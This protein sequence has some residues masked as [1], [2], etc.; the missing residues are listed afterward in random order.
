MYVDIYTDYKSTNH[1]ALDFHIGL[2]ELYGGKITV[3]QLVLTIPNPIDFVKNYGKIG[4]DEKL[5]KHQKNTRFGKNGEKIWLEEQKKRSC[6]N[7]F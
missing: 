6:C 1:S 4:G 7:R 5:P 2:N 3:V